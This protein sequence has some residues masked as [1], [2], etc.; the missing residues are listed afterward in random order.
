MYSNLYPCM[1]NLKCYFTCCILNV[2]GCKINRV[3]YREIKFVDKTNLSVQIKNCVKVAYDK[4]M[5][6]RIFIVLSFV[7]DL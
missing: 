2:G 3:D 7:F 5:T 4:K 6:Y 1:W